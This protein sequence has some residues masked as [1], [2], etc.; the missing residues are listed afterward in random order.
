MS[1]CI[2]VEANMWQGFEEWGSNRVNLWLWGAQENE[3]EW[4][5][6]PSAGFHEKDGLESGKGISGDSGG[7]EA[8]AG[9]RKD[10]KEVY[11]DK[12]SP[13]IKDELA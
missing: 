3:P 13:K 4:R 1:T 12:A 9:V 6:K 8:A 2:C 5:A 10:A 7:F 11:I